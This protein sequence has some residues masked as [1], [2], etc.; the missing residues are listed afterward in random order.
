VTK[1]RKNSGKRQFL[2][3]NFG[4]IEKISKFNKAIIAVSR[5]LFSPLPVL[6][7]SLLRRVENTKSPR[8]TKKKFERFATE[9]KEERELKDFLNH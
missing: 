8:E 9:E 7:S 5:C 1:V 2:S 6:R 3:K 4:E